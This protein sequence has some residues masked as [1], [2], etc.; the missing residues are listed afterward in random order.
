MPVYVVIKRKFKM[1]DPEE[2]FPL[3]NELQKGAKAQEGYISTET[4]QSADNPDDYLVL[5]KWETAENWEA[6]FATKERREIQGKVD[7]LIGER[8]F[9]E[10]FKPTS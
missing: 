5:S 9:Y 4:L 1:N 6:W 7:S 2:L 8:T 10:I 3:L